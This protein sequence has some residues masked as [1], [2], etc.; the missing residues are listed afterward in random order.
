VRPQGA[1]CP[2]GA[3]SSCAVAVRVLCGRLSGLIRC[4]VASSWLIAAMDDCSATCHYDA[5][6]SRDS[7]DH[8]EGIGSYEEDA[9]NQAG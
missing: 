1:H 4:R 9:E 6:P 5:K 8:S 7:S 3:S 2:H